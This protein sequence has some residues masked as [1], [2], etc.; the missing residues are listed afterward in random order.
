[1]STGTRHFTRHYLEM[2]AAMFLAALADP[3]GGGRP[4]QLTRKLPCTASTTP[5]R[6]AH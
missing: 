6:C 4:P 5:V 1:M 3:L 2:V